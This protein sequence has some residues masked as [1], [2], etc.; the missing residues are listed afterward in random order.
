VAAA[1]VVDL[2]AFVVWGLAARSPARLVQDLAGSFRRPLVLLR[3]LLRFATGVLLLAAGAILLLPLA[4]GTQTFSVL[5]T[6]T[7]LTALLVEQ[8]LGARGRTA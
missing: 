6:W 5:E 1:I 4:F 2:G 7:V 8:L 3:G